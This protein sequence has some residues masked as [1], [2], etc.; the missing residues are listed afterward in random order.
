MATK[1][2]GPAPGSF[3]TG[4]V[5]EVLPGLGLAHVRGTDGLVY[6]IN[7]RTPGIA[8]DALRTGQRVRCQVTGVLHR[9]LHAQLCS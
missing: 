6:G 7:R 8:F 2:T 9:V 1:K 4:E 3:V 5:V